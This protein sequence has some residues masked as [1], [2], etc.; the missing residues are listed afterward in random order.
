MT[1]N[2]P[3]FVDEAIIQGEICSHSAPP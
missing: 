2:A 3:G 1:S